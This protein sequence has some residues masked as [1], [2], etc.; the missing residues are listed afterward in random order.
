MHVAV[1]GET[2]H[3]DST[4][5][6]VTEVEEEGVR[7]DPPPP[8]TATAPV[9]EPLSHADPCYLTLLDDIWKRRSKMVKKLLIT[10][11]NNHLQKQKESSPAHQTQDVLR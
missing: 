9:L 7:A 3:L 2:D 5:S 11:L 1:N 10:T 6:S 8:L 4:E